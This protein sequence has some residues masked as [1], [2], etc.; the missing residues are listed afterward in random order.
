MLKGDFKLKIFAERLRELMDE[1]GLYPKKLEAE[2]G[3]NDSIINRW[4][5]HIY[6]PKVEHVFTLARYFNVS[7]GYLI[8]L[9]D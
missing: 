9:E 5:G 4:L 3:I 6:H 8:G 1:K 7:A 2:T